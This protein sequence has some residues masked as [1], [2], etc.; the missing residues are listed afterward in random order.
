MFE[1][2]RRWFALDFDGHPWW[3][4]ALWLL[5][6]QTIL[7]LLPLT[8]GTWWLEGTAYFLLATM[9]LFAGHVY[10]DAKTIGMPRAGIWVAAVVFLP[11]IGAIL[12]AYHRYQLRR[13]VV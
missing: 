9:A 6:A 12:Y 13:M 7:I 8:I 10:Q 1:H 5:V 11:P 3:I 2:I 4:V